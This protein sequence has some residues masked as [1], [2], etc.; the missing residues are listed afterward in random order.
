MSLF[1]WILFTSL[2]SVDSTLTDVSLHYDYSYY[3]EC[4]EKNR[5]EHLTLC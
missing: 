1:A 3:I 2:I 4:N 5:C